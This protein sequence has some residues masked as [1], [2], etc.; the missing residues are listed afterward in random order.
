VSLK[1]GVLVNP[2]KYFKVE[3]VHSSVAPNIMMNKQ[4]IG[5]DQRW[6]KMGIT[7]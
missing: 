6:C 4:W 3:V 7:L 2:Y 1:T 5:H